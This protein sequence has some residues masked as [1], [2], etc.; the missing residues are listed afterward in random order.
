MPNPMSMPTPNGFSPYDLISAMQKFIRR[1]M[2]REALYCFYELEAAGLYNVAATSRIS[3]SVTP[4][5]RTK[6]PISCRNRTS[7]LS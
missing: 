3:C 6:T 4:R 5:E 1:S 7:T 2:E